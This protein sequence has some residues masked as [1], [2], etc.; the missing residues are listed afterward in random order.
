STLDLQTYQ[1]ASDLAMESLSDF[2]EELVEQ[3]PPESECE[4]EYSSGVLTLSLG[5]KGTYVINKQPPN[6]QIWL[7]SPTSGP[8][9]YDYDAQHGEW[10][11]ARDHSLMRELLSTELSA[12]L[13]EDIVV[14]LGKDAT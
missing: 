9:R 3:Q 11:Y 13:N 12:A 4:V 2:L 7:S 6:A 5:S 14:T 8:K 1:R 10:F